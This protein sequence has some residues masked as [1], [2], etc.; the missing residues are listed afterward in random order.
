MICYTPRLPNNMLVS[1]PVC[2]ENQQNHVSSSQQT[3]N[4]QS[5][6]ILL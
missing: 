3:L 2:A 5:Y 4:K 6:Q 1:K